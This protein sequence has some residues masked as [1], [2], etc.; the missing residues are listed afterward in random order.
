[1]PDPVVRSSSVQTAALLGS[2]T[3]RQCG[4]ATFTKDLRDAIAG[5]LGER[6]T[7][8]LAM[9][10]R[11]GG[12]PYPP[13][14]TL[15]INQYKQADYHAAAEL[16]NINQIDVVYVQHEYG[17]Y[18]GHDGSHVLDLV[19]QLR[20]PVISTLHTVLKEPSGSQLQVLKEL[21]R[22]SDRV[23]VMS[24]L[25]VEM[26]ESI[27]DVPRDRIAM[28]PHGIPDV[29]FVDPHFFKDQFGVEGKKVLLT[30]G[31]LSPGKGIEVA[32]RAVQKI[33][34]KHPDVVYIVLG[35]THPHVLRN[36]GNAYRNSLE[37]LVEQLGIGK[38][39]KF[40]NRFVSLPELNRYISVADIYITPYP[41]KS[42][43]TSGTLAYAVGAGKPVVSTPYWHAEEMLAE[44]RGRLFN[45]GDVD[46]L[47][48]Q[49]I[50]LLDNETERAA[51]RKRAYIY[52]RPMVWTEVG[53]SYVRLAE[54]VMVERRHNP[55]Q[56]S[57][58]RIELSDLAGIP[59]LNFAHLQRMSDDTGILQHAIYATPNR[60]HGYCTDD[61]VRAL[62]ATLMAYDQTREES[63]LPL[64][65][66]YLAFVHSAYNPATR[67]FRNF[68][69]FSRKWLEEVGS[70][71]SHGRAIW[72][73]GTA[74]SLPPSNAVLALST[75][76]FHDAVEVV[77]H[78]T[79]PRAWAFTLIGLHYYLG[80]FGGDAVAR[81]VRKTLGEKLMSMFRSNAGP[82]WPWC[83]DICT[84][85][86][87]KLAHALLVAGIGLE[88]KA[89]I[90]QAFV[91]LEWLIKLQILDNGRV[92][93]IGNHGWLDR[94]GRRAKFD[95]QPIEAMALIEACADAFRHTREEKWFDYARQILSW[96]LGNNETA[97]SLHDYQTGGCR[98]GLHADG[99]NLN[100]GAESTLAWLVSLLTVMDL[101]RL[102]SLAD[103]PAGGG[104]DTLSIDGIDSVLNWN[105]S[106]VQL[107]GEAWST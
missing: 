53:K 79:S 45:F 47:A 101:N 50:D 35:A 86:N 15:Q 80:R 92:S 76:L 94:S 75:R 34:E 87:A 10:D 100:Q 65:D 55:R 17:I 36:E 16:L 71:D 26:L 88:D 102:R 89:M 49:V 52:G 33:A 8:V 20:M 105:E 104:D 98:D 56:A 14:V 23:V 28:I 70:E 74:A 61:N 4:L 21:A 97:A 67:R 2:Y 18:G 3:P 73:L 69:D 58:S 29:P 77:E 22:E 5:E 11:P 82:D 68:M 37:A 7:Q 64:L 51:M 99:A 1:M 46:G 39:V 72:S 66:R 93:L 42:Q 27:Y 6:Q 25:A 38:N 24:H 54:E 48:N 60:E 19:R 59:D 12:Y 41:N 57:N 85:D 31:L 43:I 83:E 44:G 106:R 95:Q 78:F 103:A 63:I 30:F 96:F 91:S 40:H 107:R 90:D 84:Y 9:D 32:I 62:V 81:R 13:E